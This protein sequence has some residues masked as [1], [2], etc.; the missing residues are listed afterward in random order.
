MARDLSLGIDGDAAGARRALSDTAKGVDHLADQT[1]QLGRAFGE[2]SAA[3][4]VAAGRIDNVGDQAK[5]SARAIGDLERKLL[6]AKVAVKA[7]SVEYAKTGDES[8]IN[9][10]REA[11]TEFDKLAGVAKNID[12]FDSK[13]GK[14]GN[15]LE[16]LV[17]DGAKAGTAAA[18]TFASAFEGGLMGLVKSLPPE[19]KAA[20]GASIAGVAIASAPLIVSIINGAILAGVGAGGLAAGIALAARDPEISGA[21]KSLGSRIMVELGHD[22]EPFKAQ[23]LTVAADFGSSFDKI[24]PNIKGFFAALA[25]AVSV[26]GSA[27]G[28][29]FEI[30]GPALEHAAGPAAEV[31]GAIA[32]EIPHIAREIG[33][34]LDDISEHGDS[35]AAAMRF[36]LVSVEALILAFDVLVRTVGP[37]ADTITHLAEAMHLIN[38]KS[39]EEVGMKL[40][41]VTDSAYQAAVSFDSLG[42]AVYNTADAARAANDAFN[43]LFG[44]TMNLDQANLHVKEGFLSLGKTIR[45]NNGSLDESKA[46][47]LANREAI[48]AQINVIEQ[49]RQAA[50]AAGN[51]TKEAVDKANAA[52]LVNLQRIRDVAAAA[53]ANTAQLD[54]MIAAYKRIPRD[55][56]VTFTTVF[57]EKGQRSPNFNPGPVGSRRT[58]SSR[59][60]A[61]E[62]A[63]GGPVT[64]GQPYL[65]GEHGPELFWPNGNG[66]IVPTAATARMMAQQWAGQ[67][68]RGTAAASGYV[69]PSDNILKQALASILLELQQTGQ[70]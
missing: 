13:S 40:P 61:D 15:L 53:G 55:I 51:G 36:V 49:Q 41:T 9:K 54:A 20:L 44:A 47:G 69:M 64:D 16:S 45:D 12:V 38:S 35:A 56:T 57:V 8:P 50:I 1:G 17:G 25:P 52:Y 2:V 59:L 46:K 37:A 19:A 3:A 21:F 34:L 22:V 14:K 39:I 11:R 33:R 10:I 63:A 60:G 5:Q 42:H 30:L 70:L 43:A 18:G 27:L 48:L 28:K 67:G 62:R 66:R 65:V 7:F 58:G 29:S 23:L 6:E 32:D 31:L 24:A 68:R 4:T 26:L